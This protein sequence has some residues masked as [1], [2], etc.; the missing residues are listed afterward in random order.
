MREIKFRTWENNKMNYDPYSDE[1]YSEGTP[2][3]DVFLRPV[4]GQI[5]IQYTG[6]HDKNGKEIYEGDILLIPDS[7]FELVT[8]YEGPT[9][10]ILSMG[11]VKAAEYGWLLSV[12]KGYGGDYV[13][14]E[15]YF[16]HLVEEVGVEGWEVIGNIWENPDLLTN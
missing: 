13:Y 6:L 11:I 9:H 8:D 3:N 2:I 16:S 12:P 4:R 14:G 10:D 15:M 7:E 1:Y 5:F